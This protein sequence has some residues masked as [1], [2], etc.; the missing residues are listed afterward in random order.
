MVYSML[1]GII[2]DKKKLQTEIREVK[3]EEYN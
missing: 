3:K 1:S 2:K